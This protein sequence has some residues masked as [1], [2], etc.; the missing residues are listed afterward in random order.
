MGTFAP[1]GS[2]LPCDA[3]NPPPLLLL[4]GSEDGISAALSPTDD[5][6]ETLR[7]TMS[8]GVAKGV[9]SAELCI[10]R[11]ANH[12]VFCDPVDPCCRAAQTDRPLAEGV[13]GAKVRTRLS[14]AR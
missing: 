8:E 10:L 1:R 5:A 9:G 2:V 4:G 11:G 7:R 6:T 14:L 13:D 12:M 3:S